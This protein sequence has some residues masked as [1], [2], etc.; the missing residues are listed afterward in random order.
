M[1]VGRI[2][3]LGSILTLCGPFFEEF[4]C[5]PCVWMGFLQMLCFP[6]NKSKHEQYACP[7]AA[8]VLLAMSRLHL[9][10]WE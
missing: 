3:V 6:P 4:A 10:R 9:C 8:D 5:V 1:D 2:K 7:S